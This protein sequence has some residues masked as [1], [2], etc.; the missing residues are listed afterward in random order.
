MTAELLDVMHEHSGPS[1][2]LGPPRDPQFS[3]A[4]AQPRSFILSSICSPSSFAFPLLSEFSGSIF[5]TVNPSGK[6]WCNTPLAAV[7]C[8]AVFYPLKIH[9]LDPIIFAQLKEASNV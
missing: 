4:H 2:P 6:R 7:Y 1:L 9:Q 5:S 8:C 3:R